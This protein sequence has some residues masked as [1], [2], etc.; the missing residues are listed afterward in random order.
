VLLAADKITQHQK[1]MVY[2]WQK[3]V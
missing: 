1:K 3:K 2:Q